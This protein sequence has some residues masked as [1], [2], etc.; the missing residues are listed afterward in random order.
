LTSKPDLEI[1]LSAGAD[2]FED[3]Q[4]YI[5]DPGYDYLKSVKDDFDKI[6]DSDLSGLKKIMNLDFD[7]VLC[8]DFLVKMDIATMANS[9]E[10]R[11]PFLSKELLE[12]IPS[13]DDKYKIN[14]KTTKYLLRKLAS[15]YLP[16]ELIHQPKRGFEI[17]LKKWI[18]NELKDI[19]FDYLSGN[20]NFYNNFVNQNFVERLL[21]K[22]IKIPDEKRAKILW[23]LFSME[24]WYKKNYQ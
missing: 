18:D 15:D 17:P 14:G 22:K 6:A 24:V 23:T 7:T 5:N 16:A 10:G 9:L 1:Y 20:N 12:Y 11:S 19:L 21:A 13:I 3:Y 4:Q 2:I 8:D